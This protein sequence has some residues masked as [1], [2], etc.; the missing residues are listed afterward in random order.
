MSNH[1]S[2][3][4]PLAVSLLLL[5]LP[6]AKGCNPSVTI[7]GNRADGGGDSDS[8]CGGETDEGC[9][10]GRFCITPDGACGAQ[11]TC[12]IPPQ[13]CTEE[14]APVCG[15]D[16]FT[17]SNECFANGAGTGVLHEGECGP[18]TCGD[19]A[20]PLCMVGE[21]CDFPGN[22]CGGIGVCRTVEGDCPA[23]EDPVCGCDGETYSNSCVANAAGTDVVSQGACEKACGGPDDVSC[24]DGSYCWF[25]DDAP[26]CGGGVSEGS[27][28]PSPEVCRDVLDPVC[29]CDGQDYANACQ[30][31]QLGTDVAYS[32]T[33]N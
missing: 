15:C 27:C 32:G 1:S 21:Y 28:T 5:A 26:A 10:A 11:G 24:P 25:L 2:L 7:G 20:G 3:R 22:T 12:T 8:S 14:Y 23:I 16:G 6:A 33:C 9:P 18:K 30:A 4:Y 19:T 31:R 17:Y 13:A 29:G